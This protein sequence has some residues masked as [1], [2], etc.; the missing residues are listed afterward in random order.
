MTGY[1]V[2]AP[3]SQLEPPE[4]FKFRFATESVTYWKCRE[5]LDLDNHY[6]DIASIIDDLM[7][8]IG[9]S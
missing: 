9:M 8:D 4:S 5:M 3:R 1:L 7:L 2:A 6:G